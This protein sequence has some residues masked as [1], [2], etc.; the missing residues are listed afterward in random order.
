VNDEDGNPKGCLEVKGGSGKYALSGILAGQ[1]H[2]RYYFDPRKVNTGFAQIEIWE[3]THG[4]YLEEEHV[5]DDVQQVLRIVRHFAE[6]GALDPGVR[7]KC[8]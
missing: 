4:S 7:W 2:T 8:V 5:C 3:G 6:E 1:R